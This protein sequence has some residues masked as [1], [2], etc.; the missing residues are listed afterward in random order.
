MKVLRTKILQLSNAKLVVCYGRHVREVFASENI[1]ECA[2]DVGKNFGQFS[3]SPNTGDHPLGTLKF[4]KKK[5]LFCALKH[6][7][8]KN[9]NSGK[10]F[11]LALGKE[12]ANSLATLY[13]AIVKGA[14]PVPDSR[15]ALLKRLGVV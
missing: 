9:G 15:E 2:S 10:T 5:T 14:E 4:G 1:D 7:S 11:E 12:L 6:N 8:A 13:Q 3:K